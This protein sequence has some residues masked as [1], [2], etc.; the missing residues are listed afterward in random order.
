MRFYLIRHGQTEWNAQKRVMGRQDIPLD[1][2]GEQQ[3]T[4][5]AQT[6][7]AFPI[8]TIVSSP[9]LRAQQTAQAI[10][11]V[12]NLPVHTDA[13]ISELDFLRWQ[14]KALHEIQDDQVYI[15]RKKDFFTFRHPEVENFE[16]LMGRVSTFISEVEKKDEHVAVVTHLDVVRA[17]VI[18]IMGTSPDSFFQFKI[19]NASCTI[20]TKENNRWVMELMNFTKTPLQGLNI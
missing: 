17:M 11:V 19:Q 3:I 20:L 9:Q 4:E 13:R 1:S 5:L 7:A 2:V 16:S 12:K 6:L 14:G 8:Q 10:S 15:D 18:K